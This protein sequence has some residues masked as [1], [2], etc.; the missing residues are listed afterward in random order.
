MKL[1]FLSDTHN[2]HPKITQ[3][4]DIVYHLGDANNRTSGKKELLDFFDWFKQ[5]PAKH[6]IF[7]PGNHD[8]YIY[9]NLTK[10]MP[11]KPHDLTILINQSINIDGI[12]FYG[13]PATKT[14]DLNSLQMQGF[15]GDADFRKKNFSTIPSNLDFLLTHSP[16]YKILD[17]AVINDRML[18]SLAVN[19]YTQQLLK[20]SQS[21]IF[22]DIVTFTAT[23]VHK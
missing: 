19:F 10:V 14:I 6:K 22:L 20:L 17:N 15:S 9:N 8:L 3:S 4:Y 7:V 12:S 2:D 13:S 1:L 21:I 5:I 23:Q 16:P 18:Y 11:L